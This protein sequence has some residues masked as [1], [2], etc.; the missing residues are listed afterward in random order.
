MSDWLRDVFRGRPWWM[1]AL[2]VFSAYMAFVYVPWDLFVKPVAQ[3]EEVWFGIL[4]E[5]WAAKLMA[6]PHWFVYAAGAYGFRRMRPWVPTWSALY[7]AQV[8]FGMAVWSIAQIGGLTGWLLGLISAVPFALL[9]NLLWGSGS[10][11]DGARPS[12]RDRYG[13]WALVTGASAGIG[14]EFARALAREGVSCVL[15]ARREER[16][17]ALAAELERLGVE[18]RVVAADLATPEGRDRTLEA[19]EGLEID[20]LVNNAG[21]GYAGRFDLLEPKRLRAQVELNCLAPVVL[22]RQLVPAMRE[23]GRGALIFS[24]SVAGRQPLPLHGVYSATKAFDLLLGE[25]L[26]CELRDTGVDVVVLEP[27]S[28]ETE[29]QGAAGELPHPGESPVAVVRVALE[30]LGDQP[31]VVSGW[32]NWLRANLATRLLPRPM[33]LYVAR[34]VMREQTP[35]EMR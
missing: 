1:N 18:S 19:I 3:D 30:A 23:R 17:S 31:S 34:D 11:F 24:G 8:A 10:H 25:S 5:G 4:F 6:L 33:V 7:V 35:A 29:F 26:F 14:A 15:C 9:A 32:W 28:T 13:E 20:I 21:V 16:L 2:M 27:G 12:L 22:T